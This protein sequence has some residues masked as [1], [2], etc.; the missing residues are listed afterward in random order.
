MGLFR[1]LWA[2][3]PKLT[4]ILI[5]LPGDCWNIAAVSRCQKCGMDVRVHTIPQPNEVEIGGQA[6]ALNCN[7]CK[8]G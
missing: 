1:V 5:G 2:R 8:E 7:G 4:N 6:V 3:P